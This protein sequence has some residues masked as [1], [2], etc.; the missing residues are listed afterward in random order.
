MQVKSA[1]LQLISNP[2]IVE[3]RII[4]AFGRFNSVWIPPQESNYPPKNI[5]VAIV[6]ESLFSLE[7]A[8]ARALFEFLGC[9]VE[10]YHPWRDDF[11]MD[12]ALY[13]FPNFAAELYADKLL[14]H[15]P[16]VQG[17]RQAF[18]ANKLIFANGTSAPLFG[19]HIV[20]AGG[21]KRD[22]LGFFPFHGSYLQPNGQRKNFKVEIRAIRDSMFGN[23]NEKMRGT[24][25][26]SVRI[27]NPGGVMP[28]AWAYRDSLKE[29][30][31]GN[32]GWQKA[33]CFVTDLK[34][35]LWSGLDIMNRWLALRK[36]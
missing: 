4:D 18:T 26:N 3:W 27:G 24:A 15:V 7:G 19:R 29:A 1:V 35:E 11:P 10:D 23:H 30:E 12:A 14:A 20:F 34:L 25:L 5:K 33:Y 13:Y 16:F 21:T 36:K 2:H 32:S 28:P 9:T 17:I 31:L 6:G 8:N 22:A